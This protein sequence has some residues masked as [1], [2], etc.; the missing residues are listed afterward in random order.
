MKYEYIIEEDDARYLV[1]QVEGGTIQ[2]RLRAVE[3]VDDKEVI[4]QDHK[5]IIAI[6]DKGQEYLDKYVSLVVANPNIFITA[7]EIIL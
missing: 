3:I 7:K 2:M 6:I 4:N 5:D 1:I